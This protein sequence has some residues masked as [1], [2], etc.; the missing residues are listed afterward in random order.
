M[1]ADKYEV[2]AD[3]DVAE[4]AARLLAEMRGTVP[5]PAEREPSQAGSTSP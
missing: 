2:Q 5:A 3:T 4:E 1:T